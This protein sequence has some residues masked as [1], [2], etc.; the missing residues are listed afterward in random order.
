M[1]FLQSASCEIVPKNQVGVM[2][3]RG[4]AGIGLMA[5]S[6]MLLPTVPLLALP[7]MGVSVWLLKGCP[8]CWGMHMVNA[9]RDSAK[10]HQTGA[11]SPVVEETSRPKRPYQ[12]RD[13]SAHLFPPEDVAR[14]RQMRQIDA[15]S[16]AANEEKSHVG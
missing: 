1:K 4:V 7:V 11:T 8:A 15:R 16:A 14:F 13:M 5:W 6:V 2:L 10:N 9:V 12:P 3:L